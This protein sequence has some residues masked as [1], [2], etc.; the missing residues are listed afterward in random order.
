MRDLMLCKHDQQ[1]GKRVRVTGVLSVPEDKKATRDNYILK[2]SMIY[3]N[4][5][6]FS[7]AQASIQLPGLLEMQPDQLKRYLQLQH[8]VFLQ[9]LASR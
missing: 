3:D 5:F 4:P 2:S 8:E 9:V 7:G 6:L 1:L